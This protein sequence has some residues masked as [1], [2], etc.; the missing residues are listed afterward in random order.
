[1]TWNYELNGLTVSHE[2]RRLPGGHCELRMTD[3]D[4]YAK[5]ERYDDEFAALRRQMDLERTLIVRG[6]GLGG[7]VGYWA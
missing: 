3:F 1:M 7:F 4:G 6:W 5:L 2:L